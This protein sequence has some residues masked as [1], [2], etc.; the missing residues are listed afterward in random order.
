MTQQPYTKPVPV[1][2]GESDYYWEKAKAHELWLRNCGDCDQ[3]YFYPR[4]IC[5]HCF[6]RNTSWI[7]ASGK[8]TLHT[9]AIVHRAPTPAFRDDAPF[10]VAM[11]DLE[12]GVRMPTNLVEVEPDPANITIGMEVEVVFEDITDEISLPKFKPAN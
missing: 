4:D 10:V 6:S 11:V 1:P 12:E 2:Q 5:P 3:A 7:Q 8:G 9:F